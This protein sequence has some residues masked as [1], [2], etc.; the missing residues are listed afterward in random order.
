[1]EAD[2]RPRLDGAALLMRR[3]QPPILNALPGP[4][5]TQTIAPPRPHRENPPPGNSRRDPNPNSNP[6]PA[7]NHRQKHPP[8]SPSPSL[9]RNAG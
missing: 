9:V 3:S 8:N 4:I 5:P 7:S 6:L 2:L 1:M